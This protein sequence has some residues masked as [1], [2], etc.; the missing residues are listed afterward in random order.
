MHTIF[1]LDEQLLSICFHDV[2][3]DVVGFLHNGL[4]TSLM[5]WK[6]WGYSFLEWRHSSSSVIFVAPFFPQNFSN[7]SF[8]FLRWETKMRKQCGVM[9][10][11]KLIL[12]HHHVFLF[13]FF[14]FLQIIFCFLNCYW[15][16]SCVFHWIIKN[17][18][19][20][21]TQNIKIYAVPKHLLRQSSS[22]RTDPSMGKAKIFLSFKMYYFLLFINFLYIEFPSSIYYS[23]T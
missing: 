13:L 7:S 12:V 9:V 19:K 16:L 6:I 3:P 4:W 20:K 1:P 10:P 2:S 14:S 11:C 17:N 5:H 15:A 8:S 18:N 21:K 22:F 23:V